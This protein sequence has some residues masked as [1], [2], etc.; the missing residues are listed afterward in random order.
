MR[1][2]VQ[3]AFI[4]SPP[5]KPF[6]FLVFWSLRLIV[7]FEMFYHVFEANISRVLDVEVARRKNIP[8]GA[9]ERRHCRHGIGRFE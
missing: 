9:V 5:R 6:F 8:N 3:T 7:Y 4:D 2:W 1:A